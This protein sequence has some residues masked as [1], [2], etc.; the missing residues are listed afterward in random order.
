MNELTKQK[1]SKKKTTM[2]KNKKT[3]QQSVDNKKRKTINTQ[4]GTEL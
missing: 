1:P 2:S 4:I 3:M